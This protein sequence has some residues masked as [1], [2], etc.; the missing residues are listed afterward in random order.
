LLLALVSIVLF[1]IRDGSLRTELD[2]ALV[3][4]LP[5]VA[6]VPRLPTG[7]DYQKMLRR[8]LMVSTA[9]VILTVAAGYTVWALQ[10]WQFVI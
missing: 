2:V 8:R 1:E 6:V 4:Q 9:A 7:A 5:V 3:L 10:L